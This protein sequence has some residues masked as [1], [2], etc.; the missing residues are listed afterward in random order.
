MMLELKYLVWMLRNPREARY[1][2]FA[3]YHAAKQADR[4][5]QPSLRYRLK[6]R[7]ADEAIPDIGKQ[8]FSLEGYNEEFGGV[9][10]REAQVLAAS[11]RMEKPRLLFEFGTFNGST[12]LIMAVNA[13]PDAKIHTLDLPE[14]H[15]LR[16]TKNEPEQYFPQQ[17]IKPKSVGQRFHDSPLGGKIQQHFA[18]SKDFDYSFLAGQVDWIFIDAAHTYE[19]VKNDTEHALRM[20]RKGGTIFWH[21]VN[22]TFDGLCKSLEEFAG[23]MPLVRIA[24]TSLAYYRS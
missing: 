4:Y 5:L 21:D 16:G 24:G 19:Y 13:P 8:T 15:P 3:L 10:L 23:Q 9:S 12:T 1:F 18:S 2:W 22:L 20:L 6:T 11:I 7:Q 17:H 14:D